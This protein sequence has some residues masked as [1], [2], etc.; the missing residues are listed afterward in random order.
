MDSKTLYNYV[1][2]NHC[3]WILDH[4]L[5]TLAIATLSGLDLLPV[6]VIEGVCIKAGAT[7]SSS[8]LPGLELLSVITV[9]PIQV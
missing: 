1:D 4:V 7:F 9:C 5:S 2:F 6:Y 3:E 8:Y